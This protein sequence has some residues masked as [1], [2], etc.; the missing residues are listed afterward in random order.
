MWVNWKYILL[1][2]LVL[3]NRADLGHTAGGQVIDRGN[4]Q[5]TANGAD[6]ED[7]RKYENKNYNFTFEYPSGWSMYEGFDGNGVSIY[8]PSKEKSP[9][10]PMISV[11]GSV[12][13]P[14]EKDESRPRT[15]LEDLASL[16]QALRELQD[17]ATNLSV[18][19]QR[20]ITL[21]G[22]PGIVSTVKFEQ[23]PSNQRWILKHILL[24]TKDDSVTYHLSL[25]CHSG[26]SS[27]LSPVFDKVVGTFRILGPP[28]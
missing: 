22:L 24:H 2:L 14:S 21:Q 5:S 3:G 23:G 4:V 11:G 13:Q 15:I 17:P 7:V 6:R 27:A 25:L 16:L 19:E 20:D 18:V 28:A 8:P 9:W 12:G 26:D 1:G 10:R